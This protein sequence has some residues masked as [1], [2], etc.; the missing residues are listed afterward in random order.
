[1]HITLTLI[2]EILGTKPA[3]PNIFSD[4]IASKHPSGTPQKDELDNNGT[5]MRGNA[6]QWHCGAAHRT[7]NNS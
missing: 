6:L 4:Y 2:Q 7:A 5:P 1:M 3:N